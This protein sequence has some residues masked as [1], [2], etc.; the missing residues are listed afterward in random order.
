MACTSPNGVLEVC[1]RFCQTKCWH[2]SPKIWYIAIMELHIYSRVFFGRDLSCCYKVVKWLKKK[3]ILPS[4]RGFLFPKSLSVEVQASFS[5]TEVTV[6]A[7]RS[8]N[9]VN[10]GVQTE[11]SSVS[12]LGVQTSQL[13]VDEPDSDIRANV[14]CFFEVL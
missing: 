9:L 12:D 1:S 3:L 10:A 7:G 5:R 13:A 6:Q 4:C 11:H 2:F 14:R 8:T